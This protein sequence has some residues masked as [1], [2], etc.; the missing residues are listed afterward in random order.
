[1]IELLSKSL[2]R[3]SGTFKSFDN[4]K[5]ILQLQNVS[6]FGTEDR[7]SKIFVAVSK[8]IYPYIN[9][10][11]ENID[12]I[13][14]DGKHY[15]D[16]NINEAKS[17]DE[18][19]KE[20]EARSKEN[21]NDLKNE[22]KEEDIT[23][24]NDSSFNQVIKNYGYGKVYYKKNYKKNKSIIIKQFKN[25]VSKNVPDSEYDLGNCRKIEHKNEKRGIKPKYDGNSFFD[26]L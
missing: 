26:D 25:L 7:K 8:T 23:T 3:Y 11:L 20:L 14:I 13:I 16:F 24:I 12:R 18:F 5:D 6:S 1:M 15:T 17:N 2:V 10:K 9:F 19:V 22:D 21:S 4:V